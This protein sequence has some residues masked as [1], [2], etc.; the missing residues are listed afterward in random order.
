MCRSITTIYFTLL[1]AEAM[2]LDMAI[3]MNVEMIA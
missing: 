3:E 1:S 2:G